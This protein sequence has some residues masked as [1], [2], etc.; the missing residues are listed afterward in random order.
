MHIAAKQPGLPSDLPDL[1][2]ARPNHQTM[3]KAGPPVDVGGEPTDWPV[4][5]GYQI[6]GELGRGS[7][8]V[9][10]RAHQISLD[11]VVALKMIRG[12]ADKSEGP[13]FADRLAD[14]QRFLTEARVAASLHHPNIVQLYDISLEQGS[15]YFTMELV[16]GGSLAERRPERQGPEPAS[17]KPDFRPARGA[18]FPAAR[19]RRPPTA[20]SQRTE[21]RCPP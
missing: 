13:F 20:S 11:R 1:E 9:V 14:L 7:M 10:Y 2:T 16:E 21:R 4:I 3:T 5:P 15:P 18:L 12:A 17:T 8:G 6:L 19:R